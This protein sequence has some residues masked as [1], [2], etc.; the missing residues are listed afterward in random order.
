MLDN[1]FIEEEDGRRYLKAAKENL[2]VL[3][4][5]DIAHPDKLVFRFARVMMGFLAFNDTPR[6][7]LM[8][9]LGTGL[10]AK[11]IIKNL[12][13]TNLAA[14]E[15]DPE[16]VDIARQHFHVP[17][18]SERFKTII[19]D[20]KEYMRAHPS[21]CDVILSDVF[22]SERVPD[23]FTTRDYYV[24]CH[25]ALRKDGILSINLMM[26]DTEDVTAQIELLLSIFKGGVLLVPS[27]QIYN[28]IL[29]CF[30]DPPDVSWD[31]LEERAR[32]LEPQYR[33]GL[34][35][36]IAGLKTRSGLVQHF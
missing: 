6:D 18:D 17:E 26:F 34:P 28:V 24:D 14:V 30:R 5:M 16:M 2:S 4:G 36:F 32:K 19:A 35:P 3:G 11:Y 15:I 31:Q 25:N 22:V 21:S 20:G 10:Q 23:S 27:V 8:V 12:P 7:I 33:L 13:H 9:G 1:Y 29:F